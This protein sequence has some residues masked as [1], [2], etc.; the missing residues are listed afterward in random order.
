[1]AH[2]RHPAKKKGEKTVSVSVLLQRFQAVIRA[3]NLDEGAAKN[4]KVPPRFVCRH[5]WSHFK[6]LCYLVW[7]VNTKVEL[8]FGHHDEWRAGTQCR[9]LFSTARLLTQF[10]LEP[11]E[12]TSDL[13]LT[14]PANHYKQPT[15]QYAGAVDRNQV[16]TGVITLASTEVEAVSTEDKEDPSTTSSNDSFTWWKLRWCPMSIDYNRH[17]RNDERSIGPKQK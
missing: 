5:A 11:N 10:Q 2:K 8:P 3:A 6:F 17:D 4:R 12:L 13:R 1:M 9:A 14:L 16:P 15:D 7:P